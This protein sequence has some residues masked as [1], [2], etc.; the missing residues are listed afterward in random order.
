[1]VFDLEDCL[2]L[3]LDAR[4]E[5]FSHERVIR[6]FQFQTW[7]WYPYGRGH[8]AIHA[9]R[10]AAAAILRKLEKEHRWRGLQGAGGSRRISL[11]KLQMLSQSDAY[12]SIFTEFVSSG[13]G[14]SNLL[15]TT[16]SAHEFDKRIKKRISVYAD[17]VA[18]LIEYRLR[19]ART[20]P[21]LPRR[22][23]PTMPSFSTVS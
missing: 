20:L 12:R 1:M 4:A 21:E 9:G 8:A 19:A 15:F 17:F 23:G 22:S 6:L 5:E 14:W 18:N 7:I 2:E 16:P 10:I 13:G 11:A 3:L